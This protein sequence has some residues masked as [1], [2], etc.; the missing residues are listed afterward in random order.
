V[1]AIPTTVTDIQSGTRH[2]KGARPTVEVHVI[3]FGSTLE[4]RRGH[5]STLGRERHVTDAE[6][7]GRKGQG[8]RFSHLRLAVHEH[9]P[10][11]V[12]V[13]ND[14]NVVARVVDASRVLLRLPVT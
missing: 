11:V 3:V 1:A 9:R 13:Y 14:I 8:A 10:D 12:L 6:M 4:D 7:D 2:D 5:R